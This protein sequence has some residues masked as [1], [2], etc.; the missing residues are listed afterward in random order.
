MSVRAYRI[1]KQTVAESPSFNMWHDAAIIDFIERKDGISINSN[2]NENGN[3][4]FDVTITTLK[5]LL[6]QKD[7]FLEE[8]QRTA[9]QKDIDFAIKN[10]TEYVLYDCY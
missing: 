6:K 5:K 8:Y 10:K 4:Q 1:I 9:I 7:L 2:M 3:G